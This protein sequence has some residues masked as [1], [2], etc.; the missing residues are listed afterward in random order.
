MT[1]H[2]W[3]GFGAS[4][5]FAKH[6]PEQALLVPP[7]I[8]HVPFRNPELE[9]AH[10]PTYRQALPPCKMIESPS[11]FSSLCLYL[12]SGSFRSFCHLPAT[13]LLVFAFGCT[14][15]DLSRVESGLGVLVGCLFLLFLQVALMSPLQ[16]VVN[17]RPEFLQFV[18]KGVEAHLCSPV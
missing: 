8:D 2:P 7:A 15:R 3:W 10:L 11:K 1:F 12:I 16:I 6:R 9:T 14:R 18:S 13:R 5:G 4:S 17:I